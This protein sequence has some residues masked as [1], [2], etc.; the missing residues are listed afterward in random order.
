MGSD[1]TSVAQ[2]KP[3]VIAQAV[4]VSRE[5]GIPLIVGAGIKSAMDVRKS[6][7]LG[8]AGVAVASDIV[9]ASDPRKEIEDLILGFGE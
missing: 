8:A 9:K 3:D 6:L 2:A 1:K 7:E 4:V 5:K